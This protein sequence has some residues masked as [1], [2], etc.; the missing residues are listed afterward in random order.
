[1]LKY[2]TYDI[3]FQEFPD[4]VTLAINLSLCPNRCPGCHSSILMGDVGEEL[5]QEVLM[6]LIQ[7]YDGEITCVAL[8]GGDNDPQTVQQRLLEVKQQYKELKTGWYSGCQDLPEHF[9][10][11]AFNYVKVGPYKADL[12]GLNNPNTNQRFYK[13][14]HDHTLTDLT[15][16]FRKN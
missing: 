11:A 12:G 6:Q 1:M 2:L 9:N 16:R 15:H 3:V 14:E 10:P 8:M 4:E 5:T 13:V 7:K